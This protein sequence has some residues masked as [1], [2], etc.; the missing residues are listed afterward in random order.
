MMSPGKAVSG[1]LPAAIPPKTVHSTREVLSHQCS[2][3]IALSVLSFL[4]TYKVWW[5]SL[6]T[7]AVASI[8]YYASEMVKDVSA[9]ST[10]AG[11]AL[12]RSFQVGSTKLKC[13]RQVFLAEFFYYAS[14]LVAAFQ[15]GGEV[16]MVVSLAV[17]MSFSPKNGWEVACMLLG[18]ICVMA[19]V[20][21]TVCHTLH[22]SIQRNAFFQYNSNLA[23][24]AF[25]E[26]R[27]LHPSHQPLLPVVDVPL[28]PP[29]GIARKTAA[30]TTTDL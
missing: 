14:I 19:L 7:T 24:R 9:A 12:G 20:Y 27:R 17:D 8:G 22:N 2:L 5:V 4:F 6:F 25:L 21:T 26:E 18:S 15:C 10:L 29:V 13:K 3:M 11:D 28:P 23:C 1:S 16:M 30:A